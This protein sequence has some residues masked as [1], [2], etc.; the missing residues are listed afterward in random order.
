MLQ[1]LLVR[2]DNCRCSN[3][4]GALGYWR[5]KRG[6]G[7]DAS[8]TRT[9]RSPY[10]LCRRALI[11]VPCL[12]PTL[13]TSRQRSTSRTSSRAFSRSILCS[14]RL[15]VCVAILHPVV[16]ISRNESGQGVGI[17]SLPWARDTLS[18]P[19]CLHGGLVRV[20][21]TIF[22][23]LCFLLEALN[24]T[25]CLEIGRGLGTR[26]RSRRAQ[27]PSARFLAV[28]LGWHIDSMR[29]TPLSST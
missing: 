9:P 14:L 11:T 7:C 4:S 29:L 6:F 24:L 10:R 25:P 16:E 1:R 15:H 17:S 26:R 8:P 13:P 27:I 23:V 28:C 20:R 18:V 22:G 21:P 19:Q 2:I 5:G 3:T 12:L